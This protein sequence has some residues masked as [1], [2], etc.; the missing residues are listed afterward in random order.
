M[1]QKTLH[2]VRVRFA[3]SPTGHLHIG[4]LR[5]AIFNWLFARH[6]NGTF[7]LR[8]ED[9]DK[10]RSKQEYTDAIIDTFAWMGIVSDEPLV[11]QSHRVN[12]H[13]AVIKKLLAEG[14]AYR[15]YCSQEDV[16]KRHV[17]AGGDPEF[18]AYDQYCRLRH[19]E[20]ESRDHVVRFAIPESI[21][22]ICFDDMIRGPITV[23]VSELDDFIIARS[24]YSPMYNFVVVVDDAFMN[25]TH[26][27]RGEDHISNTPKQILLYQACGYTIPFF[28]HAPN[29][30]G[31]SG[32]KLSKREAAAS[33]LEYRQMGYL[34][35]ALSNYLVRLGW[36]HG[37]QEVFSKQE[38]IHYFSLDAVGKKG[39][40]F[41]KEK[42]DWLNGLYIRNS[43]AYDLYQR[44]IRDIEP[45]LQDQLS[46]WDETKIPQAIALYQDRVKTLQELVAHLL[47]LYQGAF[48]FAKNNVPMF[49]SDNNTVHYL[50]LVLENLP[51]E[52]EWTVDSLKESLNLVAKTLGVKLVSIAQPLRIALL[53]SHDGPGVMGL[54][55][56][57]GKRESV[58][59][60]NE[61]IKW[62]Q[63]N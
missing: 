17:D 56:F 54:L 14:K 63:N 45:D 62:L 59:R 11:I 58:V 22:E 8:I 57:L 13:I 41:D 40:I 29:I 18:V 7:L 46:G 28:A 6:H 25:I 43:N 33:V 5:A 24:D 10:E 32:K 4:G 35:D 23:S 60:I 34:P 3:P 9:T 39:S 61:L 55:A 44:I 48:N 21:K 37:D 26:V 30:L 52:N 12:E 36:S 53:G 20:D 31:P 47:N 38:L 49:F 27:I 16:L 42:L 50:T 1:Q 19:Y 51:H 2:S 15:C